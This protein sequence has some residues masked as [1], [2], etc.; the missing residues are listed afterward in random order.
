MQNAIIYI[1]IY[2]QQIQQQ[3]EKGQRKNKFE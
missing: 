3:Q 2:P 1:W